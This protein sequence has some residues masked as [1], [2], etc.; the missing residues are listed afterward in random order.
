LIG[1]AAEG[2]R[3]PEEGLCPLSTDPRY[4]RGEG[5]GPNLQAEGIGELA[6]EA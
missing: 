5:L 2:W 6:D 1:A 4:L 3:R